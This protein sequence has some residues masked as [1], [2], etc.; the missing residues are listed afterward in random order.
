M[1]KN[2]NHYLYE[3]D[4]NKTTA[5]SNIAGTNG[6]IY[7]YISGLPG[8]LSLDEISIEWIGGSLSLQDMA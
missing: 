3:K 2:E 4:G 8:D 6:P 5:A 7:Q 1:M